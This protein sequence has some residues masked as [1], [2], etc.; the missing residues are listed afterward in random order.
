M[1]YF[2]YDFENGI[3]FHDTEKAARDRANN[4]LEATRDYASD[5]GWDENTDEICWGCVSERAAV[6]SRTDANRSSGFDEIVDYGM[7]EVTK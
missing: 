2:S 7:K 1:K 4:C 5:D 6:I 3:M